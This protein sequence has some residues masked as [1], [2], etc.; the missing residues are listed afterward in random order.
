MSALTFNPETGLEAPETGQIRADVA[1]RFK[2][3]FYVEDAPELD[4]EPSSPA[5][6]LVDAQVA[7]IEAKNAELLYLANMFNPKAADGRW[8]DALG[9]IYFLNRKLAEPSVAVCVLTG[10]AGTKVP[11]GMLAE[12]TDGRRWVHNRLNVSLDS[13]GKVQTTFRCSVTGPVEAGSDAIKRIVTTVP[14]LDSI[15]NPAAAVTGRD[16]ETR[17]DFEARRAASVA[18]NAHGSVPSIYGSLHDLSGAAGV[19]DVRVLENIG[20]N[21][22]V[23][24]GVTVPGH[25]ITVCIYGGTDEEIAEIIYK[26]KDAGCDTGGNTVVTHRAEDMSGA[27]Y[28]YRIMRPDTV[29]FW[30]KV[31]L[32]SPEELSN[33]LTKE[34]KDA[35]VKDFAGLSLVSGN[36]RVGLASTVYASRFY[37]CVTGT[38]VRNLLTVTIALGE[39]VTGTDYGDSVTIR[40]DQE[41]ALSEDN[42]TVEVQS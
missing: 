25:G 9:Y 42:V 20:P 33:E 3:A 6:Q 5:G 1:E 2:R 40:G 37:A 7:E 8:Q 39:T 18:K 34:I 35:V 12:D 10:L 11:Y 16:R 41:P 24:Y 4:T 27:V 21:P 15:T 36:P 38:Q 17:A 31:T 29:N 13:E 32:G 30:V 23:K 28:E 14:G 22:V 19:I 26:K